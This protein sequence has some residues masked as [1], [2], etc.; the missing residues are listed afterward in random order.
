MSETSHF[1]A[2]Q[3]SF[4]A[5]PE[6]LLFYRHTSYFSIVEQLFVFT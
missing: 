3:I 6:I 5:A 2:V 1:Q 4:S